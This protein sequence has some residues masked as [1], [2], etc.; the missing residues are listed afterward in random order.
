M[1]QTKVT[2]FFSASFLRLSAALSAI[3]CLVSRVF[4]FES[5]MIFVLPHTGQALNLLPNFKLI[6][7]PQ[8]GHVALLDFLP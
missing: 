1:P 4:Q 3:F 8:Y 7:D 2:S 6:E 5:D